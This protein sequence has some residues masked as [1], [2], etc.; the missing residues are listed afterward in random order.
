MIERL[1]LAGILTFTLSL[2]TQGHRSPSLGKNPQIN[3][4]NNTALTFNYLSARKFK[5]P[6]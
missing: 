3:T 6:N 1:L 2:F 5:I 4:N